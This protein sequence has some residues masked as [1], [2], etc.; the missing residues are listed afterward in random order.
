MNS[1]KQLPAIG[2]YQSADTER[3][4]R[5]ITLEAGKRLWSLSFQSSNANRKEG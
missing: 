1:T 3:N 2:V 4:G 5:T